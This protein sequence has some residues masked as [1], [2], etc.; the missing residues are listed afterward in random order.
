MT[1]H[2]SVADFLIWDAPSGPPPQ[3]VDGEPRAM[4]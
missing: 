4:A 3:L 1:R 2:M